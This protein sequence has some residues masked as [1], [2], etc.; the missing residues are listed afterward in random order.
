M[1]ISNLNKEKIMSNLP[2]FPET[3]VTTDRENPLSY[4]GETV[5]GLMTAEECMEKANLNWRVELMPTFAQMPNGEYIEVRDNKI[6]VRMDNNKPFQA[7]G[8]RYIP[9]QNQDCFDFLDDMV[10]EY[11]ATYDTA[12]TFGS[13]AV[14]FIMLKLPKTI[15]VGDDQVV[16]YLTFINSHNG[17]TSLKALT[18]PTRITCS[19]TLRLAMHNSVSHFTFKHTINA[20]SKMSQGRKALDI[21][22][23]YYDEFEEQTDKLLNTK[24]N[25]DNLNQ[26][27]DTVMALP[28]EKTDISGNVLNE[29]AIT[30]VKIARNKIIK[31]FENP[32][33]PSVEKNA[34]GLLNAINDWELW[35]A[36]I[37]G[38]N[39]RFERQAKS[40]VSGRLHPVTDKA[41]EIIKDTILV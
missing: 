39:S 12:G 19:N 34:W 40:M 41:F 22:F 7:V 10:Q 30:K 9:F 2:M 18:T 13:G 20:Y 35:T 14:V 1:V 26:I 33:S 27:L 4:L 37:R 3:L 25:V 28:D 29:G 8:N 5:E 21:S 16:P 24:V 6:P 17:S 23:K 11:G 38:N 15:V 31:N 32:D 36:E